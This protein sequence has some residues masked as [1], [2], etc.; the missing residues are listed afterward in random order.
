MEQK[1]NLDRLE[2][3]EALF[4]SFDENVRLI[5]KEFGVALVV[6]DSEL[7]ITGDDPEAVDKATR[8]VQSLLTLIGSGENLTEQNVRYCIRM[9]G[10]DSEDK[11]ARLA[12]DVICIT[13]KGK[14]IKPKPWASAPIAT[15][16]RTTPSPSAWALPARARPTWRWPWRSTPSGPNR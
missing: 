5:E 9:V 4:G 12:G 13:S 14:P 2:Q 8:T 7:K 1:I 3:A 15:T 10:E 16:S 6:R 11:V